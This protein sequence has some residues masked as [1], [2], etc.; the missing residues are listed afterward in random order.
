[1]NILRFIRKVIVDFYSNYMPG[2]DGKPVMQFL[3][4]T[5]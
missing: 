4:N 2:R 5:S 1:M 3:N